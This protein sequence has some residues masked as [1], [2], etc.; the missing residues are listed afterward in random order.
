VG[1]HFPNGTRLRDAYSGKIA[2]VTEG[3]ITLT[4]DYMIVLL[5]KM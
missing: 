5:E 1:P 3:K 2:T 4:T